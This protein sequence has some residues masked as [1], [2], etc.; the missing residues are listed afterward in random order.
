MLRTYFK[1]AFRNLQRNKTYAA[2]NIAGMTIGLTAFWFIALY[3]ADE[4][5]YDRFHSNANRVFRVAQHTS[6]DGGNIDQASTSA[7]FAGALKATFP[8]IQEATRVLVEG[9]GIISFNN[10][11]IKADDIFLPMPTSSKYSAIPS[12]VVMPLLPLPNPRPLY[13]PKAWHVNCLRIHK[14]PQSNGLLFQQ[15]SQ[16]GNRCY[17]GRPSQ[18]A[19][20]LQRH[21][22]FTFQLYR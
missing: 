1:T 8:E 21:S 6:W 15:L 22:L 20:A 9:G 14:S 10:N 5:S 16:P 11:P 18:Y 4:L 2:I 19:P 7:P 12:S 17:Q 13:S 3:V